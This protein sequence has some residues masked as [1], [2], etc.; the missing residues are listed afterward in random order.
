MIVTVT[1]AAVGNGIGVVTAVTSVAGT[2][3]N[4]KAV[5]TA[6]GKK[7]S[8][9]QEATAVEIGVK[10]TVDVTAAGNEVKIEVSA[11]MNARAP[12]TATTAGSSRGRTAE[13]AAPTR[14]TAVE[15]SEEVST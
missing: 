11:E 1:R 10:S 15:D 8:L 9:K 14:S 3:A 7:A 5:A 6:A 13:D 12:G 2:E 4:L